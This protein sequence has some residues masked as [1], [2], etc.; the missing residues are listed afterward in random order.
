MYPKT[1]YDEFRQAVTKV[2][3][4]TTA[5]DRIQ[6]LLVS[7]ELDRRALFGRI[8]ARLDDSEDQ[9]TRMAIGHWIKTNKQ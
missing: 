3:S 5:E 6:A 8:Q 7:S 1:S 9:T 4:I 2:E